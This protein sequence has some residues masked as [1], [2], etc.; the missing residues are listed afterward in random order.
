MPRRLL[1]ILLILLLVPPIMATVMGWL[2]APSF[3]HPVRRPLTPG[4]IRE[5]DASF[6]HSRAQREDFNVTAPDGA[7]LR[8][9][10]VRPQEPNGSWLLLFHALSAHP[11]ASIRHS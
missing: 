9:W 6:A 2:V 8:G 3:L 7:E 4:L 11:P 5:A 1:R 10:K